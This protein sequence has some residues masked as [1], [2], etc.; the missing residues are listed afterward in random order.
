MCSLT[1]REREWGGPTGPQVCRARMRT[2]EVRC[3]L[4][5]NESEVSI[6]AGRVAVKGWQCV[7][8]GAR[9]R[10]CTRMS[11]SVRSEEREHEREKE[12]KKAES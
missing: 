10:V 12:K 7:W 2:G 6:R 11:V 3:Y 9:L 5:G 1:E 4:S 8:L